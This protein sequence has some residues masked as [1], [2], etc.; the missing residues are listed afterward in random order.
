MRPQ[1]ILL[2]PI[3]FV[4][5]I[6]MA[7]C[8][9]IPGIE[10]P[11]G[12]D[13]QPTLPPP[14]TA[15]QGPENT[16][17]PP[18]PEPD[19]LH[20]ALAD[21]L[22]VPLEDVYYT[23]DQYQDGYI[24]GTLSSGEY[25]F[26]AEPGGSWQIVYVGEGPP[27]CSA[28]EDFPF[29]LVTECLDESGSVVIRSDDD[30]T[31]IGLAL[32]NWLGEPFQD[33]GYLLQENTGVHAKGLIANGYFLATRDDAENWVV[34]YDGQGTP[35]CDLIDPFDFPYEM[36]PECLGADNQVVIRVGKPTT[37][38]AALAVHLR[39]PLEAVKYE[40]DRESVSHA[41]GT[42]PGG[43]YFLAAREADGT[44]VVVYDGQTVPTCI[45]IEPYDFPTSYA[46]ECVDSLGNLVTLGPGGIPTP[47]PVAA[48]TPVVE[49][50]PDPNLPAG[51]PTWTDTF[52]SA[53]SWF[54]YED[55]YVSFDV[56]NGQAVL[57]AFT[58][59]SWD[60]WMLSWPDLDDFYLE[61]QFRFDEDCTGLDRAGLVARQIKPEEDGGYVGY[62]FGVSCDGRYSLRKWDGEAFT[63]LV[64]WTT[65]DLIVI[66]PDEPLSIGLLAEGIEFTMY[67]DGRK[68]GEAED[69]SYSGGKMGLFV[70]SANTEDLTVLV[71]EVSYW[72]LP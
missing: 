28:V 59:D 24:M 69:A 17:E 1:K 43:A 26:G 38:A 32:S 72:N 33:L 53:N 37:I 23:M 12:D 10:G 45:E 35:S 63:T 42:L 8:S 70:A 66:D 5:V 15:T 44:W 20:A 58:D 55:D 61:G 54:L 13:Q 49:V 50:T 31:L 30:V 60:G 9:A 47:T 4:L 3:V 21:Y 57:Q 11:P 41:R 27:P 65:S 22:Q 25:Y 6:L 29:D 52:G 16:T 40:I 39:M 51:P 67:V 19:E 68:L 56:V 18:A 2:Y 14:A 62:L 71:D 46:P 64:P 7:A 34:V 36:V 48:A